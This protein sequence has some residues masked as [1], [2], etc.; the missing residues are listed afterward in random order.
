MDVLQNSQLLFNC[1]FIDDTKF[2]EEMLFSQTL[3]KTTKAVD[4][5]SVISDFLV[6]NSFSW[7]KVF[8]ICSDGAQVMIGRINGFIQLIKEKNLT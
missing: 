6:S 8:G 2:K 4:V 1:K 3:K 5:I 7:E